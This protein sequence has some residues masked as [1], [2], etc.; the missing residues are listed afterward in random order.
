MPGN[1]SAPCGCRFSAHAQEPA[2]QLSRPRRHDRTRHDRVDKWAPGGVF[3]VRGVGIQAA[4][5]DAAEA[6][7]DLAQRGLMADV[8]GAQ[9]PVVGLGAG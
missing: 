9:L 8:A 7:R 3:A 5:E 2:H 1:P 6:V 4:V